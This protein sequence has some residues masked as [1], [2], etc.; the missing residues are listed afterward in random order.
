MLSIVLLVL[1]HERVNGQEWCAF[2]FS[3]SFLHI[4]M[5][6]WTYNFYKTFCL[7][8]E[9]CFMT[10][11]MTLISSITTH[12]IFTINC[13]FYKLLTLLVFF[14]ICLYFE[15]FH[16]LFLLINYILQLQYV[17][18]KVY[19]NSLK[20]RMTVAMY[21]KLNLGSTERL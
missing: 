16:K 15:A 13:L 5:I 12:W 6:L 2:F 21:K 20:I 19:T 10:V 8:T 4:K 1:K 17:N 11:N 14:F 9:N 7:H 18:K 3:S